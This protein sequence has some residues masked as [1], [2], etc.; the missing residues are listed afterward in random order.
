MRRWFDIVTG[1]IGALGTSGGFI[2]CFT[3]AL[4]GAENVSKAVQ[5]GI[6]AFLLFSM[7]TFIA[8]AAHRLVTGYPKTRNE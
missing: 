3:V 2:M 6:T 1:L 4:V 5:E 7:A 8:F